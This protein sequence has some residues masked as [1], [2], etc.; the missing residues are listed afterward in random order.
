MLLW[1]TGQGPN[2]KSEER[3]QSQIWE[4]YRQTAGPYGR[5]QVCTLPIWGELGRNSK[6]LEEKKG[7][8]QLDEE[9]GWITTITARE[10]SS[11]RRPSVYIASSL[12][13]GDLSEKAAHEDTADAAVALGPP[14][15]FLLPLPR[16]HALVESTGTAEIIVNGYLMTS[17]ENITS[18][19]STYKSRRMNWIYVHRTYYSNRT[20]TYN[21]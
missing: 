15:P 13:S 19:A 3:L 16:R 5:T 4:I 11:A 21:Q 9:L 2:V 20:R 17:L 18:Y 8:E 10:I 7:N 14:L 1:T 12:Y 6:K